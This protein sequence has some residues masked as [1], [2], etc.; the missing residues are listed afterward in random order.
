MPRHKDA[1]DVNYK[2]LIERRPNC[3][4][5]WSQL[6]W[7]HTNKARVFKLRKARVAFPQANPLLLCISCIPRLLDRQM[8]AQLVVQQPQPVKIYNAVYS[9]VQVRDYFPFLTLSRHAFV[10]C[11]NA[12]FE[13][14]QLCVVVPTRTSMPLRS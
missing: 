1:G 3:V 7:L 6:N 12:W 4:L 13:A 14:S 2:G 9:S 5:L 11:M 8:Q 10:R